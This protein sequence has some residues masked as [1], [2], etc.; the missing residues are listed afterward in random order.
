[1]KR[2][3]DKMSGS[4]LKGEGL[5]NQGRRKAIKKIAAGAAA[6]AGYS[7]LPQRWTTPVIDVMA[8]PAHAQT[9]GPAAASG[10]YQVNQLKLNV[11]SG[12]QSSSVVTV[13]VE[14]QVNPAVAGQD[15]EVTFEGSSGGAETGGVSKALAAAGSLFVSEA[16]AKCGKMK[17]KTKTKADGKFKAKCNLS[18]GP[19]VVQVFVYIIIIGIDMQPISKIIYIPAP[20]TP[21]TTAAP[22]T[23]CE[24]G[25]SCAPGTTAAPGGG[26]GG[27][28]GGPSTPCTPGMPCGGTPDPNLTNPYNP[29]NA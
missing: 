12:N 7:V 11:L 13:G 24:P 28:T 27:G 23:T 5:K 15:V 6:L 22:G 21:T 8:L 19:G 29:S 10:N 17:V 20:A 25:G 18:C 14:G 4:E 3:G 26:G 2:K 9:S 16:V 1:M